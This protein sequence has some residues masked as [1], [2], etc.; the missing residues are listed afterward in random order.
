MSI[1][2]TAAARIL[3]PLSA[4]LQKPLSII[5]GQTPD[6]HHLAI[7]VSS[8][9]ISIRSED[10]T[11][12]TLTEREFLHEVFE[13]IRMADESDHRFHDIE[14]RLARLQRENLDLVI[15]NR[16]LSEVSTRD[17]LTGLYNRWYVM[18]KIDTEMNR[19]L[20]QGS[21]MSILLLDIDHF[22]RV[23]DSYGHSAGD[24]VLK[25]VGQVLRESCR[26]YDVPGRYGGEEF[27]VVLP[28]T[29]VGN[30]THVAERIRRRLAGTEQPVG[31]S[32][33]TVTASIGIAGVDCVPEDGVVSASTLV[34]RADRALYSAKNRGRNRVEMWDSALML[35]LG[36]TEH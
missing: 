15:K 21:P 5:D 31:A 16:V 30:T 11:P 25:N 3:P 34:E 14:Q 28:G 17:A 4:L 24:T 20:R 7:P 36:M 1:A 35:R 26:V 6:D 10:G 2:D 29:R 8:P 12:F 13:L 22:K 18:E 19:S 33:I 9:A 32:S 27:C 23:N